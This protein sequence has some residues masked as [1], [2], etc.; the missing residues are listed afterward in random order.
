MTLQEKYERER[1]AYRADP[2]YEQAVKIYAQEKWDRFRSGTFEFP[3]E[4]FMN[5]PPCRM[6]GLN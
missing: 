2:G 5:N 3:A 1:I 6:L 4:M